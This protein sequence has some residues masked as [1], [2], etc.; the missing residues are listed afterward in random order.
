MLVAIGLGAVFYVACVTVQAWGFGTDEAGVA[1]FAGSTAPLGALAAAYV[2]P[3]QAAVLHAMALISAVGAGL[4]CVLVAVRLLFAFGR[5]GRLPTA[6]ARISRRTGAP[7]VALVVELSVGLVTIL[8]FRLAGVAPDRMFFV[9]ATFGV[10][11]LLVMYAVTDLA[12]VRHLRRTGAAWPVLPLVG[13]VVAVAVLVQ[14]GSA[15]PRGLLIGLAGW[16]ALAAVFALARP[17][18]PT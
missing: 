5:D 18:A 14:S 16:L 10:L 2:G 1:A 9:L 8:G 17:Q 12:A 13:A 15:V 6:L 3:W 11:N 4:G 7:T